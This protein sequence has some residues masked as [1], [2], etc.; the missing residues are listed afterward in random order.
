MN[1]VKAPRVT[2]PNPVFTNVP[3]RS[4]FDHAMGRLLVVLSQLQLAAKDFGDLASLPREFVPAGAVM[5]EATKE[6]DTIFETLDSWHS[7]H[8]H[9][10]KESISH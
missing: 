4:P 10:P 3:A 1:K 8:E 2:R 9:S 6:L 5:Q 7:R